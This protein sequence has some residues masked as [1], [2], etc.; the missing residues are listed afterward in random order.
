MFLPTAVLLTHIGTINWVP[1]ALS[2]K[3]ASKSNLHWHR[4]QQSSGLQEFFFYQLSRYFDALTSSQ[5]RCLDKFPSSLF[6]SLFLLESTLSSRSG[7]LQWCVLLVCNKS[8]GQN[9]PSALWTLVCAQRSLVKVR[10]LRHYSSDQIWICPT[11]PKIRLTSGS[12]AAEHYTD[13]CV[14]C[15]SDQPLLPGHPKRMLVTIYS[16]AARAKDLRKSLSSLRF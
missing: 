6:S 10:E 5:F 12:R 14:H 4:T 13:L 8:T 16:Y 9:K 15:A 11:G 1:V 7:A 2:S 3:N